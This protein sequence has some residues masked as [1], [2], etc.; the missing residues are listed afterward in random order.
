MIW[1]NQIPKSYAL[2]HIKT[3]FC[4]TTKSTNAHDW[5]YKHD[6]TA[7]VGKQVVLHP[8]I[9]HAPPLSRLVGEAS[10]VFILVGERGGEE[11][12]RNFEVKIKTA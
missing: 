2:Q 1:S 6:V 4:K 3:N 12:S 11:G 9:G 10:K 5:F 7:I 8:P